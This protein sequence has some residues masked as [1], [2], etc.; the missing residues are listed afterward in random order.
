MQPVL[1]NDLIYRTMDLM[2]VAES[3][4][5]V[6]N[7]FPGFKSGDTITVHYKI[8]EGNKE[9]I[10]QFR[11]VVI[12]RKGSSLSLPWHRLSIHTTY[13]SPILHEMERTGIVFWISTRRLRSFL[14]ISY[15]HCPGILK[16]QK[17]N[18][19]RSLHR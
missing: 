11:G 8:K 14:W 16:Y 9:R 19:L 5:R 2:N 12:Q 3:E 17:R 6:K 7:E 4:F 13:A 1:Q 10:Q 18:H 15:H